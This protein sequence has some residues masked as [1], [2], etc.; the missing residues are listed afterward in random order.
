MM[1]IYVAEQ[2][3]IWEFS[4]DWKLEFWSFMWL[5]VYPAHFRHPRKIKNKKSENKEIPDTRNK[6]KNREKKQEK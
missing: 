2:D 5:S 3:K 1:I 6:Q 4:G